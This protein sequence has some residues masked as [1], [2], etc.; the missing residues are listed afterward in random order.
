MILEKPCEI[1]FLKPLEL[2]AE[3]EPSGFVPDL[4]VLLLDSNGPL[5]MPGIFEDAVDDFPVRVVAVPGRL[6][7][8][9]SSST[10]M[11]LSLDLSR[12]VSAE[13]FDRSC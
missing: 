6:D 13:N 10:F 5:L 7:L 12:S 11:A 4:V 1:L 2:P 8:L 9:D 3:T